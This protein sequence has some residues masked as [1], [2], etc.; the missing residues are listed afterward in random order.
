M[1]KSAD[2]V[3]YSF[4]MKIP[5]KVPYSSSSFSASLTT[6]RGSDETV[7]EAFERCRQYVIAEIEKDYNEYG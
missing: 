3:S 4:N 2:R 1:E 7:E 6:D 5:G